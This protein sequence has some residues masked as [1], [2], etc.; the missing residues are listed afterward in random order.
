[1]TARLQKW[2]GVQT[3]TSA[4][5]TQAMSGSAEVMA[6]QP[7][8]AQQLPAKPPRTM[9]QLVLGFSQTVYTCT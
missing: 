4:A 8:S 3:K 6:Y 1:M 5:R 7:A 9:F 2:L